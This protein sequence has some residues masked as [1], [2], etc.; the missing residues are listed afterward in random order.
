[1]DIPER[2][3]RA[4][5]ELEQ[6]T[7]ERPKWI[8][9]GHVPFTQNARRPKINDLPTIQPTVAV[10]SLTVGIFGMQSE[11]EMWGCGLVDWQG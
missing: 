5:P 3:D 1:M 9:G 7:S 11:S 6:S 8:S 10:P 4:R 2:S